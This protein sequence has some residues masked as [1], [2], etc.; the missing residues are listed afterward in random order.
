MNTAT[1]LHL[2][3]VFLAFVMAF[4]AQG[5][6]AQTI[7]VMD[8]GAKGDCKTDDNIAIKKAMTAAYPTKT[9]DIPWQMLSDRP[10]L[11]LRRI[12]TGGFLRWDGSQELA[13]PGH[14]DDARP[15]LLPILLEPELVNQ[16]PHLCYGQLRSWQFPA[17][18]AR[19]MV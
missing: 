2:L 5:G 17:S 15:N 11:L 9:V 19:T 18:M 12:V 7:N 3:P 13:R 6:I 14:T 16:Q 10:P 4:V 1:I 8:Y